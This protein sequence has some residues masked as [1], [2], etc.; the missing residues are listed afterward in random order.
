MAC[1][2]PFIAAP[3]TLSGSPSSTAVAEFVSI[4]NKDC[5][6]TRG[7]GALCRE[8]LSGGSEER[9]NREHRS[10]RRDR[11]CG[12]PKDLGAERPRAP[13][14]PKRS[15]DATEA[16]RL[17]GGAAGWWARGA[18]SHANRAARRSAGCWAWHDRS[19]RRV[20]PL[21][22][23]RCAQTPERSRRFTP[24]FRFQSRCLVPLPSGSEVSTLRASLHGG[25]APGV[26]LLYFDQGQDPRRGPA[27]RAAPDHII[28]QLKSSHVRYHGRAVRYVY[29][30]F[31]VAQFTDVRARHM[32]C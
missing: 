13:S 15:R 19:T 28:H 25:V 4:V 24:Y 30:T 12:Q 5:N 27:P 14:P 2:S 17:S 21:A 1:A 22:R 6:I 23:G 20:R 8:P 29:R 32:F 18:A 11:C 10:G 16:D 31:R 3:K 7:Q 9:G 26:A